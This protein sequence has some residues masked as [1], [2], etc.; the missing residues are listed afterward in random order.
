MKKNP[1]NVS[2]FHLWDAQRRKKKMAGKKNSSKRG[3]PLWVIYADSFYGRAWQRGGRRWAWQPL[4]LQ[5]NAI[6]H[7]KATWA[8]S[9]LPSLFFCSSSWEASFLSLIFLS[10]WFSLLFYVSFCHWLFMSFF[11]YL[12]IYVF[13][14]H[15]LCR[16][17]SL[18]FFLSFSMFLRHSGSLFVLISLS[19]S[20][21]LSLFVLCISP[22]I[23]FLWLFCLS[24]SSLFLTKY[25]SCLLNRLSFISSFRVSQPASTFR[26]GS[27]NGIKWPKMKK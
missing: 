9:Y 25:I 6:Q 5:E 24:Y 26:S 12:V 1:K 14:C 3:I 8:V 22:L 27:H 10:F 2:F 13:L 19:F 7:E 17:L 11:H 16:L 18:T 20:F 23:L 15:S 4:V 21:L